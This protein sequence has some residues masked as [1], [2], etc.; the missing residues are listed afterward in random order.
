[1]PM[2]FIQMDGRI[3]VLLIL[4]WKDMGR[5]QHKDDIFDT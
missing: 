1:M 5:P 3:L 4:P 2:V